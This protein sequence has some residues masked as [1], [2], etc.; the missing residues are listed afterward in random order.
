MG[1]HHHAVL[2]HLNVQFNAVAA[3]ENGRPEGG[4][5]VFRGHG[6]VAPVE[7][8]K[9]RHAAH[10]RQQSV[11]LGQGPEVNGCGGR[12]QG[13][14]AHQCRQ[15]DPAAG[16]VTPAVRSSFQGD[17]MVAVI[18]ILNDGALPQ[19]DLAVCQ[20]AQEGKL[21]R[22]QDTGNQKHGAGAAQAHQSRDPVQQGRC[23]KVKD[24]RP[25]QDAQVPP[26]Q[27]RKQPEEPPLDIGNAL[28]GGFLQTFA[29]QREQG[30]HHDPEQAQQDCR[31]KRRAVQRQI[32]R[33]CPDDA[34]DILRH[35]QLGDIVGGHE[36]V[37][38][39]NEHGA[40]EQHRPIFGQHRVA[41]VRQRPA[42]QRQ[43][44]DLFSPAG[45]VEAVQDEGK[46]VQRPEGHQNGNEED[47]QQDA[48]GGED[49]VGVVV[50]QV[51]HRRKA[52]RQPPDALHGGQKDPVRQGLIQQHSGQQCRRA[53]VQQGAGRIPDAAVGPACLPQGFERM[54]QCE[55]H[56]GT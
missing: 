27:H 30:Q 13:H 34:H 46:L 41:D 33:L 54:I 2:C 8:D 3:L 39:G 26:R 45:R 20:K 37:G 48:G 49:L 1:H 19:R 52:E 44:P 28:M 24:Q 21:H 51:V 9:G 31:R 22:H 23:A 35:R 18:E 38:K 25:Q 50:R 11:V 16:A 29:L 47:A 7:G 14:A 53:A 4:N 32:Q 40:V 17:I 5:R 10:C 12:E 15:Q 42:E 43:Q 6:A 56:L 55:F 36:Q